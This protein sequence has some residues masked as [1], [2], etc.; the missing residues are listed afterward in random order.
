MKKNERYDLELFFKRKLSIHDYIFTIFLLLTVLASVASVVG[1]ILT[2]FPMIAN[3]KWVIAMIASF[4]G[5]ILLWKNLFVEAFKTIVFLIILF[6]IVLPSW[7]TGGGD[8]TITMLYMFLLAIESLLIFEKLLLKW[9]MVILNLISLAFCITITYQFPQLIANTHTTQ[10]V[11]VDTLIQICIIFMLI[12]VS[13]NAYI[14]SYRKQHAL[15]EEANDNLEIAATVDELSQ[16]YNRRKILEQFSKTRTSC[17]EKE[18]FVLMIDLDYFKSINDI[19]GHQMGDKAIRH[20]ASHLSSIIGKEAV[21]RY[22]GD[23]FLA[24]FSHIKEDELLDILKGILS[25]PTLDG[26]TL[27]TSAGLTK[28]L[29]KQS[30]EDV[31]QA[32]D[33]LLLQAKLNGRNQIKMYTGATVTL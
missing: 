15:L 23:E 31:I 17:K 30:D 2:S 1:N 33:K 27:T 4:V 24:F 16:V 6:F 9:T 5:F 12:V 8:N 22:G 28:S 29:P 13:V 10:N 26:L 11:F 14:T 25:V 20:F 19:N 21:G 18:L 7:F 3:V 32:A